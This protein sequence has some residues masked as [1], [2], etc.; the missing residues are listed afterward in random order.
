MNPLNSNPKAILETEWQ[1]TK[2]DLKRA[3]IDLATALAIAATLAA[4]GLVAINAG[5]F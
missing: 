5:G 2:R 3:F 4:A 1:A